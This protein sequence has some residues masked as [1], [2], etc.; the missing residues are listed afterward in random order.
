MLIVDTRE[1][2]N[3]HILHWFNA[4][5]IEWERKALKTGDYMLDGKTGVAIERKQNLSELAHNLLSKDKR[6]FY[7]EVRRAHDAGIRLIVLCEHSGIATVKDVARWAPE[8]GRASGKSLADAITRLE[9][10]YKVPT[11]YCDR[12]DTARRIW[13]MLNEQG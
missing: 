10:S 12:A 1:K 5:G 8:Y 13:E 2:A 3:A 11:F 6:R 7:A 4:N 9:L